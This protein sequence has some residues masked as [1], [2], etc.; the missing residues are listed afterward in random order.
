M[1]ATLLAAEYKIDLAH[2]GKSP[3]LYET[4]LSNFLIGKPTPISAL[5]TFHEAGQVGGLPLNRQIRWPSDASIAGRVTISLSL[6]W[7][8]VPLT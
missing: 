3:G 5:I 7:N 8:S 2:S 6:A 4:A 1:R